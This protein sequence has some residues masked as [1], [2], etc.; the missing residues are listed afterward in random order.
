[1]KKEKLYKTDIAAVG[2]FVEFENNPDGTGVI[3]KIL[4]RKN[5]ISRKA[6]KIKGSGFRGERLEQ[7]IA[8]NIDNFI[9]VTSVGNPPFNN[10]VV[11]RLLVAAESSHLNVIIVVNKTDLEHQDSEWFNLY[12]KIGY[13][14]IETSVENGNGMEEL[15][16][17]LKGNKNLLWGQSGVGKSS[18]LNYLFPEL[19]LNVGRLS[20]YDMKGS[21]TTVTSVMLNVGEN[22]FVIDTP[23]I[24]EIDPY[25]IKKEFLAHYFLEFLPYINECR[26]N[27]CIH[28]HE[29]GCA[30]IESVESGEISVERY[31]S[32][33][34]I[35]GTIEEDLHF[36]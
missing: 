10:K 35:L 6:P 9:L 26:F 20:N 23:G 8:A 16:N 17:L 7:V 15:N 24:R 33:L 34:R 30:I 14:L 21:H 25:G 4:P 22:T 28:E 36:K 11:D 19:E 31:E 32:Y 18:I 12:R 27:T 29:P 5:Y 2:D 3:T 1:M 13:K